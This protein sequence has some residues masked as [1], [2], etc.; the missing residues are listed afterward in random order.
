M[1]DKCSCE[2][3]GLANLHSLYLLLDKEIELRQKA[4][5]GMASDGHESERDALI[6]EIDAL[7]VLRTKVTNRIYDKSHIDEDLLTA[8]R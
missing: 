4:H 5:E 3:L 7:K 1:D 2:E 8:I 6:K